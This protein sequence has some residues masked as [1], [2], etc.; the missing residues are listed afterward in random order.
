MVLFLLVL[1]TRTA[2]ATE[3]DDSDWVAPGNNVTQQLRWAR[4]STVQHSTAQQGMS[5]HAA[6]PSPHSVSSFC[7]ALLSSFR[8]HPA[9]L[10]QVCAILCKVLTAQSCLAALLLLLCCVYSFCCSAAAPAKKSKR[11]SLQ[12]IREGAVVRTYV[13]QQRNLINQPARFLAQHKVTDRDVG[14]QLHCRLSGAHAH[15]GQSSSGSNSS[16]SCSRAV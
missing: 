15:A 2:K 4:H 3:G 6:A 5:Q 11:S 12:A 7:L 14:L 16:I 1:Q 13:Q 8:I 10:R 9:K